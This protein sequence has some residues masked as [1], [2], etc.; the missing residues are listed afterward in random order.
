MRR[1]V[2]S[3]SLLALVPVGLVA[4]PRLRRRPVRETSHDVFDLN[5]GDVC[6]GFDLL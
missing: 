5:F 4:H 6:G 2:V 3:M 1:A